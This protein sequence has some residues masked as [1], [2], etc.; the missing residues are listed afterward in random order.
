MGTVGCAYGG[1]KAKKGDQSQIAN[2]ET[3]TPPSSQIGIDFRVSNAFCD[4]VTPAVTS[5]AFSTEI[6]LGM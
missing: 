1:S 5:I 6:E 2:S 4:A 3:K